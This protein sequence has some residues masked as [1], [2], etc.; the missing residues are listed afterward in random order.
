MYQAYFGLDKTPFPMTPDPGCVYLTSQ[1]AEAISGLVFGI[2]DRKGYLL[3]TGEAGLG[4]TTALTAALQLV[5]KSKVQSSLILNP[6]LS[7]NEFLEAVMLDFGMDNIPESKAQRLRMLQSFLLRGDA[8]GRVSVVIIDEAHKLSVELLEEIRLLGNFDFADHKLLQ[9][10][11]VGQ[12]ELGP[13]LNRDDLRQLKQRIAIRLSLRPLDRD[14]VGHYIQFRWKKAGGTGP[15]PFSVEA[16]EGINRWSQGIPRLINAICDNALLLAFA[17]ESHSVEAS[18]VWEASRDLDLTAGAKPTTNGKPVLA[19]APNGAPAA[20]PVPRAEQLVAPE[21]G[22][23]R[24]PSDGKSLRT[25]E[26]Y[27]PQQRSFLSRWLRPRKPG[28]VA[29]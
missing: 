23:Y 28:E 26:T 22:G 24:L 27:Y 4:K 2:L 18:Q 1:H 15:A 5:T 16:V 29:L 14:G 3:L 19:A 6:A 7:T 17:E 21:P 25:L 13:M 10:V 20:P 12:N 9:I 8:E 11:L